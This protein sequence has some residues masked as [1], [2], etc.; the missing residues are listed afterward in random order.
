MLT[1]ITRFFRNVTPLLTLM[2]PILITQI[3]QAGYGLVDT[4]MAGN[5]SADDLAAVAIG[6]SFWLPLFLF[7]LGII[8]A[9]TPLIGELIG[10]KR[11]QDIPLYTQQ[12]LWFSL[13]CGIIACLLLFL[14]P[15]IF[16]WFD[17]PAHLHDMARLYLYGVA[18]GMPAVALYTSLRCYT[19]ALGYPVPVTVISIIGVLADIPL[20]Y[21]FIYGKLGLPA[22]GG[23]GCGFATAVVMWLTLFLLV[24]YVA[25]SR[26]Y[27]K[28][29]FYRGVSKPNWAVISRILTLGLPIGFAIFFEVSLFGF[30]AVI[31]SP[32]GSTI[33]SGHQVAF[34]ITSQ[35]FMVPLSLALALTIRISTCY[36]AQDWHALRQETRLGF[37]LAVAFASLS[38]LMIFLF[39]EP[40]V[41]LYSKES[42]VQSLATHLLLFA[43]AYQIMDALQVTSAGI[44]RGIQD[45]KS[46]MW[47]TLVCYWGVA[48]PLGIYLSRYTDMSAAGFWTA[49]VIGL[50]LAA[51]LLFLRLRHQ[52]RKLSSAQ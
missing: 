39:K 27:E 36:G 20:N 28:V 31:L 22:M 9:T 41:L 29:R 11:E 21:I 43:L 23:A 10:Q 44:L 26:T 1:P 50:T 12:S 19:E 47:V 51:M 17:V 34:S 14:V 49:L 8:I 4:I 42:M 40:L 52:L 32:L 3:A 15:S 6:S 2:L 24:A 33:V 16:H 45:T 35:L 18:L 37:I 48:L 13:G 46:P 5:V 30:A 38:M 25:W 7:M